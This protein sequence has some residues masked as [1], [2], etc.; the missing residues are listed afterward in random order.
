[1]D[2]R[3]T[4]C[5]IRVSYL[6]HASV[7]LVSYFVSYLCCTYVPCSGLQAHIVYLDI[8]SGVAAPTILWSDESDERQIYVVPAKP[9]R[10]LRFTGS[11]VHAVPK[12]AAEHLGQQETEEDEA[13][14]EDALR[15]VLLFNSW[16]DAPPEGLDSHPYTEQPRDDDESI[17]SLAEA[18][19]I[20]STPRETWCLSSILSAPE[21]PA[22]S[23]AYV[24]RLMGGPLRRGRSER[25][26]CDTV[27]SPRQVVLEA[28]H[29]PDQPA[30]FRV[31]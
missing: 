16:P 10:L 13:N 27:T 5:V 24:A 3:P 30:R 21:E 15:Q 9:S 14:G 11:W 25:F 20:T 18:S 23:T 2:R 26:R 31:R 19:P 12:P 29:D 4:S 8:E 22:L 28:L 6:C 7:I 1:M 17:P